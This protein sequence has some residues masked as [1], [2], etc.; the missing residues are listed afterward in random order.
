[1]R[2]TLLTLTALALSGCALKTADIPGANIPFAK[3]GYTVMGETTEEACG[4]YILGIDFGHLFADEEGSVKGGT[5]SLPLPIPLPIGGGTPESSRALHAALAKIP[6]ATHLLD[7][8]VESEATGLLLMGHPLFGQR[9]ST[10]HAWGV[11]IDER[12]NPQ[13]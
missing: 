9:C 12:P 13:Q 11:K 1:M 6:E 5:S 8:R 10:V 4:S 7:T 2:S 3:A